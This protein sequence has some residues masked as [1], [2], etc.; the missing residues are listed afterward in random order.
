MIWS[1]GPIRRVSK[2]DMMSCL[3]KRILPPTLMN[4]SRLARC[5]RRTPDGEIF[6]HLAN[7]GIV[8]SSGAAM[9]S[10]DIRVNEQD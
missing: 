8:S 3:E 9:G 1:I 2:Y 7:S 4:G 5:R 10:I 6:S